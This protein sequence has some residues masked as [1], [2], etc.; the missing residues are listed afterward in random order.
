MVMLKEGKN[1]NGQS[2]TR[3]ETHFKEA[4]GGD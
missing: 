2:N 4:N 3:L 1:K